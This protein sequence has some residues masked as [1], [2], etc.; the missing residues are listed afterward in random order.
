MSRDI[1]FEPDLICE[2]CGQAGAYDLMGD[3]LCTKC[4]E[5]L[6]EENSSRS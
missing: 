4:L 6:N 5:E 2:K 1:D 3:C